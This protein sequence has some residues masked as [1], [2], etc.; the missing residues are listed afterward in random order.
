M[1]SKTLG[2]I[3][4]ATYQVSPD[5]RVYYRWTPRGGYCRDQMLA[6]RA[7]SRTAKRIRIAVFNLT[8]QQME[9]KSVE[10]GRISPRTEYVPEIDDAVIEQQGGAR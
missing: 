8:T 7:I 4:G 1:T 3:E 9:Y 2:T 10:P 5:R 6:A